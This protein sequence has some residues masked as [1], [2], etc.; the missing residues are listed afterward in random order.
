[1]NQ[2]E[3]TLCSQ[4][5]C[6]TT[7]ATALCLVFG[8]ACAQEAKLSPDDV[9][10]DLYT[11]ENSVAL[12]LGHQFSDNRRFGQYRGIND[13][14][15]Y[16]LLDL[17][18]VSRDDANGWWLK[19]KGNNSGLRLDHER[20]G[21]WSYFIQGNQASR[22]EPLVVTTGL[23]GVG[24]AAQIVS[25]AAAAKSVADL[26][27]NHNIYALGLRK[28]LGEGFDVRISA[29]QDDKS[30]ARMY[31]RGTG[32]TMEFL[33]EPIDSVTRQWEVV[34]SYANRKLQLSGGYSGSTYDNS[35][36]VL[37]STGGNAAAAAFGTSYLMALPLSNHAHQL[38]LAGGYNW[39]DSTRSSFKL[40]RSVAY[41]N[42]TFD[43][44]FA[45]LPSGRL[46]G[47]PESLNGKVVT[48]LAF[49]DLTMRPMDKL[50]LT[51]S[52]RYEDRDDQTP[53]D[54]KF[55]PST[56]GATT[57][58]Y[59]PRQ[60]KQ[61]KGMLEASYQLGGGYRLIGSLEQEDVTRNRIGVVQGVAPIVKI[62]FPENTKETTERIEF[63]RTMSESLNGG[64]ALIHSRR[65]GSEYIL[66]TLVLPPALPTTNQ[67]AALL[68]ADR[69]RDK[70][71]MTADWIPADQW[72]LQFLA[73]FSNDS[74]SGRNMGP[75]EG[76]SQFV[77]GDASY[78]INETWSLAT[79]LSQEKSSSRQKTRSSLTGLPA[80]SLNIIW[81][82]DL[83]D[84]TT[85]W[86]IG[87]KGKPRANLVIGADLG[88]SLN[89]AESNLE[90]TGGTGTAPVNSLPEYFYRQLTLKM[91]ADYALD[92][93]SGIRFDF[94]VDRRHN[95]DWTWQNWTYSDGTTV[96]NVPSENSAFLGISYR[97]RWR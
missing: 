45:V 4:L 93:K 71:R 61:V 83:R 36:P 39:S 60:L 43:P 34:A 12:G 5:F 96:T 87:L 79:W 6:Q 25:A 42:E 91:F 82:A 75:R 56:A 86:G 35:I 15:T 49:T 16:G 38:H 21:D 72:S 65:S 85:A 41:Q 88:S 19:I 46:A 50:D 1:M 51:G 92:R 68:W 84:T 78:Q 23:Q 58:F 57:G 26:K 59:K 64:L 24:T 52:L 66:D 9:R 90:K 2:T 40:S 55:I 14:G 3:S 13:E 80:N 94:I 11:L 47:S 29:K 70:L 44:R 89:V 28:F 48:T 53:A 7:L 62:G 27:I 69:S 32:T 67:V 17:N 76:T 22:S 97:Y 30:G 73:D 8:T 63:K 54:L 20:Q 31:G 33:T 95:N 74:F 10:K 37:N 18:L 81:D 77:S